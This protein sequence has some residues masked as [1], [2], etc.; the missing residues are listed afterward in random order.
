M[1]ELDHKKRERKI[2]VENLTKDQ[3]D[4][5]SKFLGVEMARIMDEANLKCSELLKS[6]GYETVISYAIKKIG[7]PLEIIEEVVKPKKTRKSRK[8]LAK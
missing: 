5:L 8:N 2:D 4:E 3:A 6:I 7:E 1:S